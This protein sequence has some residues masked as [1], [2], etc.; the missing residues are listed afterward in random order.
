LNVGFVT[1]VEIG[2][3]CLVELEN[4]GA[5]LSLVMTLHDDLSVKKSGRIYLDDICKRN[6]WP[7]TKIRHLSDGSTVR[8]VRESNLDWLFIVG[9]S[10]IAPLDLLVAPRLG[11][12]GMH[13]TLLPEGRGNAAIP[14]AIIKN[15][16]TTGVTMFKLDEGIDTGPIIASVEIPI[17]RAETARSLYA[18]SASGHRRLIRETWPLLHANAVQLSPQDEGCATVWP[19]RRPADGELNGSMDVETV[20]RMVRALG[21]PYP[22]AYIQISNRKL[23][24][25]EG[26]SQ[27][28]LDE[29]SIRLTFSDGYYWATNYDWVQNS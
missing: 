29:D 21:E 15:L 1:C 8:C 25:W 18:K 3:Q 10:Q 23:I 2:L 19:R 11:C 12:I 9:W 20:S 22:G 17:A 5:N 7:L 13:P 26:V 24:I 16:Q 28:P 6:D 4:L 27:E 14:W